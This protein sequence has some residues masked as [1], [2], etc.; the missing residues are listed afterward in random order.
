MTTQLIGTQGGA[1]TATSLGTAVQD[2]RG[3]SGAF[4]AWTQLIASVD[5][6]AVGVFLCIRPSGQYWNYELG[7][8]ASGSET[9]IGAC[10]A[11]SGTSGEAMLFVPVFVPAGS[12]LAI[13]GATQTSYSADSLVIA[14]PVRSQSRHGLSRHFRG[15]LCGVSSGAWTTLDAG[16]TANTK[17]AYTQIIASTARDARGYSLFFGT[18][19]SQTSN[20]N[21]LIDLA[22]GAVA[23]EE[24][25]LP[26]LGNISRSY[27][28][29]G[30]PGHVGPIWT[31]IP[32]S[33]RIAMRMQCDSAV[34][35]ERKLMACMILW[36]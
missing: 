3:A 19:S 25:I 26:N 2:S 1:N 33:S 6:D 30:A 11:L 22:V 13:R 14:Y 27:D 34:A 32:A 10:A 16:A 21:Y 20:Q 17:S 18:P 24:I 28:Y 15:T 31:P 36:E 9:S 35:T 8:G 23:S 5:Y 29:F 7:V 12:R 4:G